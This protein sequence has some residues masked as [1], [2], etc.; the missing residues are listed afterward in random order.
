V[1][2]LAALDDRTLA[3]LANGL[4]ELTETMGVSEDTATLLF[5]DSSPRQRAPQIRRPRARD[6]AAD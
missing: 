6:T 3:A 4:D 5:E 2:A 1:S